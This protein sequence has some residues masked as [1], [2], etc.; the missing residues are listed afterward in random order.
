MNVGD[1]IT[2]IEQVRSLPVGTR[3]RYTPSEQLRPQY[4]VVLTEV[5]RR[6]GGTATFTLPDSPGGS[7]GHVYP[8]NSLD[9]SGRWV[10]ESLPPHEVGHVF[11]DREDFDSI[12]VGTVIRLSP[13]MAAQNN[14]P[15]RWRK[16]DDDTFTVVA[17]DSDGLI[18]V[19]LTVAA[20]RFIPDNYCVA[21]DVGPQVG[22]RVTE[23]N[24]ASVPVGTIIRQ[25]DSTMWVRKEQGLSLIRYEPTAAV[26]TLPVGGGG[27]T[28]TIVS[29]PLK[30][31][32]RIT[33][34]EQFRV[35]PEGTRI[36][37]GRHRGRTGAHL[38]HRQVVMM[39]GR[40]TTVA[41]PNRSDVTELGHL[42]LDEWEIE[43]TETGPRFSVGD[44]VGQDGLSASDLPVGTV[45]SL[46]G[47]EDYPDRWWHKIAP[48]TWQMGSRIR[49][50]RTN[51]TAT[52]EGFSNSWIIKSLPGAEVEDVCVVPGNWFTWGSR[53]SWF[54]I[55]RVEGAT[56][57]PTHKWTSTYGVREVTWAHDP[58]H[59]DTTFAYFKPDSPD[60]PSDLRRVIAE[61][62]PVSTTNA[63]AFT[64]HPSTPTP[65]KFIERQ[66]RHSV[67]L[68]DEG[69]EVYL[70]H[71]TNRRL[72]ADVDAL[73]LRSLWDTHSYR[74]R[75]NSEAFREMV[76]GMIVD[77]WEADDL[78]FCPD[79]NYPSAEESELESPNVDS[80]AVCTN[81]ISD[82]YECG[83]CESRYRETYDVLGGGSVCSGC[84]SNYYHHCDPCDGWYHEDAADEHDHGGPRCTCE[85][86][87]EVRNFTIRNDG[88]PPLANDTRV[89]IALPA[90][91]ISGEG[92]EEIK[93]LIRNARYSVDPYVERDGLYNLSH[94][95]EEI[96][97]V[98]Q[99]RDGNYTKRLSRLAYKKFSLKLESSLLSEV[100]NIARNHSTAVDFNIEVTRDLNLGPEHFVHEDSCWWGSYANSRCWFKSHGGFGLRTFPGGDD[101]CTDPDCCGGSRPSGRAWVIPLRRDE[102]DHLVPT[103]ETMEPDAFIV[104]NG[105][106]DLGGYGPARILAHMSGWTYRKVGFYAEPMYVNNENGYL[107]APEEI[108]SNYTDGELTIDSPVHFNL[109]GTERESL[110]NVA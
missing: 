6:G 56:H 64:P 43:A 71:A 72:A 93:R 105:Y 41:L 58:P 79:C 19:G 97:D 73:D 44:H 28:W 106:G 47:H 21:E 66:E 18:R 32:D 110:T 83:C 24:F 53:R 45:L 50:G 99:A 46:P 26:I 55:G 68:D 77:E 10:I 5:R 1:P 108:A 36:V 9:Y 30:P 104:F 22:D 96:G 62:W 107:V 67:Y 109:F 87:P 8:H 80:P 34:R 16:Q 75:Y 27:S 48:N 13:T 39:G 31:G 70:S 7:P 82:Y 63:P 11:T 52:D 91:T 4:D 102:H 25:N 38:L 29:L 74:L 94:S 3:L 14:G 23:E 59:Y 103:F 84:R 17:P 33:T 81:C 92:I 61:R 2:S 100:G 78:E 69:N 42:T 57:Y 37:W 76:R 101:G 89:N 86:P 49:R 95:L 98:W 85:S 54:R 90:G 65:L 20:V 40:R 60:L 88:D 51:D 15:M 12:P 35:L